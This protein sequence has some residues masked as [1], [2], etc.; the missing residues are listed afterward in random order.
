MQ[1]GSPIRCEKVA[2]V[3]TQTTKSGEVATIP[4]VLELVQPLQEALA[5]APTKQDLLRLAEDFECKKIKAVSET[6]E[7]WKAKLEKTEELAATLQKRLHAT[8]A[9]VQWP[10]V[11]VVDGRG[12]RKQGQLGGWCKEHHKFEMMIDGK[13]KL[14]R[15]RPEYLQP[16]EEVP[17]AHME[18]PCKDGIVASDDTSEEGTIP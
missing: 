4:E 16:V 3:E 11:W 1:D 8:A 6:G 17:M 18:H 10:M 12:G 15:V 13:S 14:E 2:E 5:S 7:V 9:L